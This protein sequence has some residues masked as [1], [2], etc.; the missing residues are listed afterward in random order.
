MF[1][2]LVKQYG[3]SLDEMAKAALSELA[4]SKSHKLITP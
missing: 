2:T 1:L 4:K 3:Q